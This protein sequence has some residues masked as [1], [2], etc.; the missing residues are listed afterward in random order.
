MENITYFQLD[1]NFIKLFQNSTYAV[2]KHGRISFQILGVC[3]ARTLDGALQRFVIKIVVIVDELAYS[4]R[5][6]EE[7]FLCFFLY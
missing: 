3:L 5:E 1:S 2:Q 6:V 4:F 7:A